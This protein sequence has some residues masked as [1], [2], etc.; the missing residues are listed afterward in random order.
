MAKS[1]HNLVL[2]PDVLASHS[3][4]AL[5]LLLVRRH[6]GDSWSFDTAQLDAVEAELEVLFGVSARPA[7]GSSD[8]ALG[9]VLAAMRDD[10]NVPAALQIALD[11][12]GPAARSLIEILG[13]R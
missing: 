6:F 11:E 2:V 12:G 4:G 3:A 5:R 10:L 9:A 1:A 8:A 7:R 13:L